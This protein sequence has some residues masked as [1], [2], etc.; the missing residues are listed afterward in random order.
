MNRT[1]VVIFISCALLTTLIFGC[2]SRDQQR[3]MSEL[4]SANVMVRIAAIEELG[5]KRAKAAVPALCALTSGSQPRQIR[6]S[7]IRALGD[8][9]DTNSVEILIPLAR[10]PDVEIVVECIEAMGKLGDARAVPALVGCLTNVSVQFP[11]MWA[12][13]NIGG[14]RA[15]GELTP[16]LSAD[17]KFV[18]Y[19][20]GLALRHIGQNQ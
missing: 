3:R 5:L 18:R 14:E 2:G 6:L 13:G 9:G 8:I 10:D 17:D 15:T 7:S 16:F 1:S 11:A 19:N 12:L 4:S 20:A